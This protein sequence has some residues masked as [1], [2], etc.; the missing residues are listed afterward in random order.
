MQIDT[1]NW[2]NRM[3][4]ELEELLKD[5]GIPVDDSPLEQEKDRLERWDDDGGANSS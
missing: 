3:R 2:D 1:T 5:V 4:S